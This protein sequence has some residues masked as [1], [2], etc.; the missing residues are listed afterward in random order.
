MPINASFEFLLIVSLIPGTPTSNSAVPFGKHLERHIP[1]LGC[2]CQTEQL[3]AWPPS[4]CW[5]IF[6]WLIYQIPLHWDPVPVEF[7]KL[8][9]WAVYRFGVYGLRQR[10][11]P[12]ACFRV[13]STRTRDIQDSDTISTA[14]L[15]S[16][17]WT[18][19]FAAPAAAA[20]AA[21]GTFRIT[22][23]NQTRSKSD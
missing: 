3:L 16:A 11:S 19:T 15:V 5:K 22:R 21:A 7:I 6:L 14:A 10:L 13:T 17:A 2:L 20:A 12:G 1:K 23:S 9:S 18:T 4:I 8:M